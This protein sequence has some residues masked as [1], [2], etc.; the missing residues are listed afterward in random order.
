MAGVVVGFNLKKSLHKAVFVNRV[1]EYL[2]LDNCVK[3][4]DNTERA[5]ANKRQNDN[6]I[7]NNEN[8]Y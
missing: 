8:D 6:N 5:I 7:S 3:K 4:I 1:K 2:L